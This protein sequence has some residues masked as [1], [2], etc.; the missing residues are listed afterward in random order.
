MGHSKVPPPLLT[1]GVARAILAGARRVSLD[2]GL[3]EVDVRLE[4][5][6]AVLPDGSVIAR[7]DL[8]RVARQE[9]AVYFP[10]GG[11]LFQVALASSH[12]Y[13]LL[14][15]D[16]APTLEIDGVRMH[17]T[18]ATTPDVDTSLKLKGLRLEGSRV[19]DT[20]SGLGYTALGA[21]RRGAEL[22]VSVELN[23]EVLRI[24]QTNPWSAGLLGSDRVNIV[25]GDV[26]TVAGLFPDAFF[27][28]VIHD[29]PPLLPR[30]PP[31]RGG[32]LLKACPSPAARRNAFPLHGGAWVEVQGRE[33]PTWRG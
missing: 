32:V 26:F 10:Q 7:E 12:F 16:G 3:S 8:E 23:W 33:S 14:P 25:L 9:G 24:A 18:K 28:C 11:E 22:V 5:D 21:V 1:A 29:P 15:T 2:L 27:D 6:G 31:L 30:G 13:K 4:R 20:C 17:R 19:L